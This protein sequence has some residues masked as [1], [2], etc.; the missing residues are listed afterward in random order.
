MKLL[1]K[2]FGSYSEKEVKRV[3]PI[4]DAVLALEG[5]YAAMSDGELQGMTPKLKERLAA[6][7]VQQR[8]AADDDRSALCERHEVRSVGLENDRLGTVRADTP[9]GIYCNYSVHFFL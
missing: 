6:G 9:I 3:R 5:K 8:A 2:L 4:A 1:E 7:E